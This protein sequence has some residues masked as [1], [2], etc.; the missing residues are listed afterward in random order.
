MAIESVDM[1]GKQVMVT[2]CTAGLGRAAA[3]S[4]AKMGATLS[5]VCR[6]RDKGEDLISEIQRT[7]GREDCD[8][9]VG[10]MNSLSD[11]RAIAASF[12]KTDRALDVLFNNAGVV[13]LERTTTADGFE[14]TFGVNHLA[15][16]L[17]TVLLM[18]RLRASPTARVVNTA[19]DAYKFSGGRLNFEDLQA[20]QKYS[21]FGAYGSS[22]LANI[23]FTRELA[24]RVRDSNVTV[25]AFHPGMV[26]SDFAKNNGWVAQV[27]MTLLR[28]IARSPQKGAETGIYLCTSPEVE[29]RT[30]GYYFNCAI[31][32]TR[33]AARD[34]DDALRLWEISEKLTDASLS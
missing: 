19:S 13:M 17:L 5:L 33:A 22:K 34:D 2:G 14:T 8:L 25:N 26:G 29:G 21:T 28:P 11:I 32:D 12:R 20:E 31:H 16:F 27:A 24:R 9:Y 1:T 23:L 7:S 30:G 18:D 3:I 4:L 6:N 10:D 15:Y